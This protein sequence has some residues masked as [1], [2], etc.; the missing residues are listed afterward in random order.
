MA[1]ASKI[2]LI[3]S[4]DLMRYFSI[5]AA[6][7]PDMCIGMEEKD[8]K[9]P[10]MPW[11]FHES[12]MKHFTLTT[13]HNI[14]IMGYNTYISLPSLK[15]PLPERTNIVITQSHRK[16]IEEE[17]ED[18]P[19]C[20]GDSFYIANSFVHALDIAASIRETF[21]PE[22]SIHGH[23][24]IPYETSSPM[25]PEIYVIGGAQVYR[26]AIQ[27]PCCQKICLSR[28][29]AGYVKY[30]NQEEQKKDDKAISFTYFPFAELEKRF[31]ICRTRTFPERQSFVEKEDSSISERSKTISQDKSVTSEMANHFTFETEGNAIFIQEYIQ[32]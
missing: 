2:L 28:I 19:G 4:K 21:S 12:D 13:L 18:D 27:H 9:K 17:R 26:Q 29:P 25:A 7:S 15:R 8:S 3:P 23:L 14:V 32:K 6:V 22:L 1:D 16:E 24:D 20:E 11:K 30:S 5:I 31:T 10:R